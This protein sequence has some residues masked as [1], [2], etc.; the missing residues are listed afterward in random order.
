[1][2]LEFVW[3]DD[4]FFSGFISTTFDKMSK[5]QGLYLESNLF[6]GSINNQFLKNHPRLV[7]IDISDNFLT[8]SLPNHLFDA[9]RMPQLELVDVHNNFLTGLLPEVLV[10][11]DSMI[12]LTLQGNAFVG[13]IPQSWTKLRRLFHLD[14]SRNFLDGPLPEFL[15]SMTELSYLF[16]GANLWIPGPIPESYG[17]LT[18]MEEFSLKESL[19]TGELPNWMFLWENLILLDLDQNNFTGEI[20]AS[21]GSM[22]NL[23]F[24]FLNRNNLVGELP[25]SFSQMTNLRAIFLEQNS[26][27]GDLDVLCNLANFQDTEGYGDDAGNETIAADCVGGVSASVVCRC[28]RICCPPA[29][30]NPLDEGL[31][32]EETC[33]DF[34]AIASMN[35]Y[36]GTQFARTFYDFGG[37]FLFLDR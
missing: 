14:L 19:R 30:G 16:L 4:N 23:E 26:L 13:E 33:H 8:G 3:L 9:S 10:T 7:Q 18:N 1:M 20:P 12:L 25:S 28:C 17:Q 22:T 35:P 24:L 2:N 31:E 6:E 11:N 34:T 36:W 21:F 37:P 29:F 32:N 27:T 5:L 15:G